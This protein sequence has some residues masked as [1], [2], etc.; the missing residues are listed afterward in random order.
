MA[1]MLRA[2]D[3]LVELFM[4]R[5]ARRDGLLAKYRDDTIPKNNLKARTAD[6]EHAAA[7]AAPEIIAYNASSWD[8]LMRR[9]NGGE[10]ADLRKEEEEGTDF[11]KGCVADATKLLRGPLAPLVCRSEPA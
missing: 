11:F 9:F 1:E 8:V 10:Q 5:A 3:L 6:A 2:R 4:Q 7:Q